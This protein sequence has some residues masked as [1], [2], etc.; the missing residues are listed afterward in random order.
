M[1][2]QRRCNRQVRNGAESSQVKG[3][4]MCGAVLTH[5]SGAVQTEDY[6]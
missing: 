4:V 2:I 5:Q 3:S 6:G 1:L